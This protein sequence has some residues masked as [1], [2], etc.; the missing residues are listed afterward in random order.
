MACL[1]FFRCSNYSLADCLARALE[2]S[3]LLSF[4]WIVRLLQDFYKIK[5]NQSK[6]NPLTAQ[7]T[8]SQLAH[9]IWINFHFFPSSSIVILFIIMIFYFVDSWREANADCCCCCRR[10]QKTIILLTK[11]ISSSY[12]LSLSEWDGKAAIDRHGIFSLQVMKIWK[13]PLRPHYNW[14]T[15][16][17]SHTK[18]LNF[19]WSGF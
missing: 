2:E 7:Q 15:K 10:W 13:W 4:W 18:Q 12:S 9:I 6:W 1:F 11:R 19:D 8:K 3:M 17:E 16:W 14:K 5:S